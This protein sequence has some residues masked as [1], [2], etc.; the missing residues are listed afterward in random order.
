VTWQ[1]G[2]RLL[3]RRGR[4]RLIARISRIWRWEFWP[5]WLFYAPV[6]VW[7]TWLAIRHGGYGTIAAANPGMPDGGVV[8]ESKHEILARLPR[9]A[10]VPSVRIRQSVNAR[11][12]TDALRRRLERRGWGFPLVLKPDVGQ[13]GSGVRIARS[14]A[15]AAG[16]W[17]G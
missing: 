7:T 2:L 12:R 16:T 9:S 11:E 4:Q 10:T 17:R 5:P 14:L 15:D 6:A 13:R 1:L 3:S 8:G